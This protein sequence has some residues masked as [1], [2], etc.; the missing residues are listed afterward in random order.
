MST[1]FYDLT[2]RSLVKF[3]DTDR[4]SGGGLV[5]TL[6]DGK[7]FVDGRGADSSQF[8]YGVWNL[9]TQHWDLLVAREEAKKQPI[10]KLAFFGDHLYITNSAGTFSVL[11][12]PATNP[13]ATNWSERPF[14][15]ISGW[16]LV[17]RGETAPQQKGDCR[18]ILLV[19]DNEGRYPGP[20]F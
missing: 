13:V 17:C 1:T 2:S 10:S 16:T 12:L 19:R 9:R 7:L 11:A 14:G 18:E 20:W 5:A 4:I 6:S 8:G 3:G 15:R